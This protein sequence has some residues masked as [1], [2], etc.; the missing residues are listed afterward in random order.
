MEEYRRAYAG[1][2]ARDIKAGASP[3]ILAEWQQHMLDTPCEFV[4]LETEPDRY[5]AA[6]QLRENV[7]KQFE[8]T[9]ITTMQR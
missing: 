2:I 1:A 5:F 4:L 9:R 8:F 6:T 3:A 7:A